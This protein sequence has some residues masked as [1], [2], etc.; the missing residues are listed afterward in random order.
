MQREKR[1]RV[2]AYGLMILSVVF[3][4]FGEYT[5]NSN[6]LIEHKYY[7]ERVVVAGALWFAGFYY[8]DVIEGRLE[9]FKRR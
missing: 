4:F 2:I 7:I 8:L 5:I 6:P 3:F 1:K 9:R